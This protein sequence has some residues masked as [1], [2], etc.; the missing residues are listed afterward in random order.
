MNGI[1]TSLPTGLQRCRFLARE[2]VGSASTHTAA[3]GT[4]PCGAPRA[5]TAAARRAPFRCSCEPGPPVGPDPDANR[6]GAG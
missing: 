1:A 4:G 3:G 5:L 2:P 6:R